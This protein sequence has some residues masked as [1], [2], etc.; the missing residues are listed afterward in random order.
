MAKVSP[1]PIQQ[2]EAAP[3]RWWQQLQR[4]AWPYA[5]LSAYRWVPVV[6]LLYDLLYDE[7]PTFDLVKETLTTISLVDALLLTVAW[8][9]P[10]CV[11]YEELQAANERFAIEGENNF[12]Y[13]LLVGFK[14]TGNADAYYSNKIACLF[15]LSTSFLCASLLC[16]V[17]TYYSATQ[18]SARCAST[19]VEDNDKVL[20]QAVQALGPATPRA[21]SRRGTKSGSA[22]SVSSSS[23]YYN[24]GTTDIFFLIWWRYSKWLILLQLSTNFIGIGCTF[25]ACG[26]LFEVKFPDAVAERDGVA[27]YDKES[28]FGFNAA[29]QFYLIPIVVM[30]TLLV[31]S[32]ATAMQYKAVPPEREPAPPADA[33][34]DEPQHL[35]HEDNYGG[36]GGG[37]AGGRS[38]QRV[39]SWMVDE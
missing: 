36:G 15:T 38:N 21:L 4:P 30:F 16:V 35:P 11:S 2:S 18:A 5:G 24:A 6:N 39:T 25:L 17:L 8:S 34:D 12:K 22:V 7:K 14:F 1:A 23:R 27:P 20:R 29:V 31:L 3:G 19:P 37:A 10:G 32:H 26:A 9:I 13:H 33:R 28:A